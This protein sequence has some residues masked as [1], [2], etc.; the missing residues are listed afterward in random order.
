MGANTLLLNFRH[1]AMYLPRS[2]KIYLA[3]DGVTEIMGPGFE[4]KRNFLL[5]IFD[6]FDLVGLF[7][8]RDKKERYWEG[9]ERIVPMQKGER[10][11]AI[12]EAKH[13][14]V[15]RTPWGYFKLAFL[16]DRGNQGKELKGGKKDRDVEMSA[17]AAGYVEPTLTAQETATPAMV[18]PTHTS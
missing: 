11:P 6:P 12:E 8:G 9:H 4:D 13:R 17:G 18:G 7:K 10:S 5:T 16:T 1:P 3:E 2:N 15:S 14:L